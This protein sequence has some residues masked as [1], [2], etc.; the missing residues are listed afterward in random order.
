MSKKNLLDSVS[1]N[2]LCIRIDVYNKNQVNN[3]LH[4]ALYQILYSLF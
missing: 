1:L 4:Q 2:I 3:I